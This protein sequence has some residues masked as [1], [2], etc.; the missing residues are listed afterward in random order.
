MADAKEL[1]ANLVN[2]RVQL[3]QVEAA[4]TTDP[5][6]DELKK[7][8]QDLEEVITLTLDLLNVNERGAV[9]A[10]GPESIRWKTGDKCQAVWSQDG[11]YYDATV[12]RISD[13]LTTCTVTFSAFGNSEIVKITSL[14]DPEKVVAKKRTFKEAEATDTD[15]G[16]GMSRAEKDKSR[17][18]KKKK[19]Q[20]KKQK[21]KEIEE[22]REKE[23]NNWLS[24]FQNSKG[25]GS[26]SGSS[27]KSLK[28]MSK[29]SIFASPDTIKGKVG[30]GTCGIGGQPMTQFATPDKVVYKK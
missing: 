9:E 22:Q 4:L 6:N 13:D 20:K 23:K 17:E 24:F 15:T 3:G 27:K 18:H 5:E 12:D 16:A 11:N 10:P 29:K 28:G 2:Y 21:L 25:S 26:G 8:K 19:M 7:L 30:V 14:R 1:Q